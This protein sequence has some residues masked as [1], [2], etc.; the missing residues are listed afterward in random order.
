MTPMIII[1]I[2]VVVAVLGFYFRTSI[3]NVA[4]GLAADIE[5]TWLDFGTLVWPAIRATVFVAL[6]LSFIPWL[7]LLIF[8]GW[9]GS[10][11]NSLPSALVITLL[12]PFWF[13]VF[14]MPP[15]VRRIRVI[16][17]AGYVLSAVLIIATLNLSVGVWSPEIKG[18]FD[19]WSIA[20]KQVVT[21]FFNGKAS[22]SEAEV[23]VIRTMGEDS[24]VYD[25]W[26]RMMLGENGNRWE[27]FKGKRVMI[28][29]PNAKPVF[30]NG[31]EG[32]VQ[33]MLENQ[34]GHF[35]G[36]YVVYVPSRTL[37]WNG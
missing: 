15:I 19:R 8:M 17:I 5:A 12:L 20:Q 35:N 37:N 4:Q 28:L 10:Y 26:G 6:A 33:V 2:I 24:C 34:A 21:Y 31:S 13:L 30:I 11:A 32:M 22:A 9:L 27:I 36:G 3:S 16:N 25:E 7:L 29:D 14:I 18:S 1:L 23:G